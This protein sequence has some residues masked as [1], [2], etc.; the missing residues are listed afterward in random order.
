MFPGNNST[1]LSFIVKMLHS[2]VHGKLSNY[3]FDM[4]MQVIKGLPQVYDEFV[5]WNIHDAKKLLRDLGLGYECIDACKYD[6]ALFWKQNADLENCPTCKESRYKVNDGKGKKI[7][8]K[9][10]RYFPLIPRLKRLYGSKKTSTDMKWHKH[11]CVDDGVLR[12][13]ADGEEWKNFDV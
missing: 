1:I 10:L 7:P 6:C 4:I 3:A 13:P 8:H 9:L 12:H 11:K 2:K 5:P